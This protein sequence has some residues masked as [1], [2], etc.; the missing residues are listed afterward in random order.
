MHS[1]SLGEVNSWLRRWRVA[2]ETWPRW[3]KAL[4]SGWIVWPFGV[5][6]LLIVSLV[7]YGALTTAPP[8]KPQRG[9]AF[10]ASGVSPGATPSS[11]GATP[12]ASTTPTQLASASPRPG[13]SRPHATSTALPAQRFSRPTPG[14]YEVRV[15]GAEGVRFGSFGFCNRPF[16]GSTTLYVKDSYDGRATPNSYQF[17]IQYSSLHSERHHYRY[18]RDGVFLEYEFAQVSCA[19]RAQATNV[20]FSPPQQK[21]KLPLKVGAAW[22]GQGGDAERTESYDARVLRTETLRIDGRAVGTYLIETSVEMTGDEH[23]TRLQRWWYAPSLA[24]PVQWH[25]EYDAAQGP[26]GYK[27]QLTVTLVDLDPR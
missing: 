1:R 19:G 6:S 21:V 4:T 15:D 17:D 7:I 23:G 26:A 2:R 5:I 25:E 20:D 11:R 16:P 22:S 9:G 10:G 24:M 14:S 13:T 8:P 27:A 3:T 12:T 18:T